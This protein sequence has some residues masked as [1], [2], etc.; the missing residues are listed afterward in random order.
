[1]PRRPG[2]PRT[3]SAWRGHRSGRARAQL[4]L[5]VADQSGEKTKKPHRIN[6][7]R[8]ARSGSPSQDFTTGI[9]FALSVAVL[10]ITLPGSRAI[11]KLVKRCFQMG[12]E[13]PSAATITL[14]MSEGTC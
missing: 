14:L 11:S 7:V 3:L 13:S 8:R 9:V 5:A 6:C 10:M 4:G 1:M 2:R 12:L